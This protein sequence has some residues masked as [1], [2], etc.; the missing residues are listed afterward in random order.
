MI[1]KTIKVF[2]HLKVTSLYL[3]HNFLL[4]SPKMVKNV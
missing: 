1:T 4:I 2:V 3:K